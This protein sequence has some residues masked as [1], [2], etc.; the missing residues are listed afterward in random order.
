MA[1]GGG[2]GDLGAVSLLYLCVEVAGCPT[3]CR[4]CGAQ[5]VGYGAMPLADIEW[6]LEEAH[7]FCD[8]AGLAFDAYPMHEMASARWTATQTGR[9]RID[10]GQVHA[11]GWEVTAMTATG[12]RGAGHNSVLR[13]P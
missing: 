10:R 11:E 4:H 12:I 7:R 5:G 6:V 2:P 1:A 3:V 8:G 9:P 13:L